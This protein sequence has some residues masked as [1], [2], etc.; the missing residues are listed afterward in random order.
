MLVEEW[1][2]WRQRSILDLQA[3]EFGACPAFGV[4]LVFEPV[5]EDEARHIILWMLQDVFEKSRVQTHDSECP[6]RG[7]G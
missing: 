2:R 6:R 3:D 5:G 1:G 7:Y 4:A